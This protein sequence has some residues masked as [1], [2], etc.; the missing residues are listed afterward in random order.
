[1]YENDISDIQQDDE[2][3]EDIHD[4]QQVGEYLM[5]CEQEENLDETCHNEEDSLTE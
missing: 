3:L 2:E 4:F 5:E 1:M